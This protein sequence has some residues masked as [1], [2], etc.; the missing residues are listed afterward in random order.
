[1]LNCIIN[2][3]LIC[4]AFLLWC[5]NS[6]ITEAPIEEPLPIDTTTSP[7]LKDTC[8]APLCYADLKP[9]PPENIK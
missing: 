1:M 6:P 3:L 4:F 8:V 5:C 2:L 7:A 9:P